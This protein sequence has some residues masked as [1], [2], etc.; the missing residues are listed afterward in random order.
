MEEISKNHNLQI[1]LGGQKQNS[2]SVAQLCELY[3]HRKVCGLMSPD[4]RIH[5]EA[6]S[7]KSHR[8]VG[9]DTSSLIQAIQYDFCSL[10]NGRSQKVETRYSAG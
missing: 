10:E 9:N 1:E 3:E 6:N 7:G 5:I 4:E 2:Y 8:W